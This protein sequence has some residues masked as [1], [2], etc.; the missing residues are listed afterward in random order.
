MK[1]LKNKAISAKHCN[2]RNT[3][4]IKQNTNNLKHLSILKVNNTNITFINIHA[5]IFFLNLYLFK[6][7]II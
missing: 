6:F 4:P 2:S 7:N 3:C 5:I 1:D